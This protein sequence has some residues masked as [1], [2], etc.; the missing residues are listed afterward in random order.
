MCKTFR[1]QWGNKLSF[2]KSTLKLGNKNICH[3]QALFIITGFPGGSDGK[4]SA[5]DVGDPTP[6]PGSGRAPGEGNEYLLSDQTEGLTF[7]LSHTH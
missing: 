6:I 7:S 3:F 4:E 1:I 2:Q 5:C